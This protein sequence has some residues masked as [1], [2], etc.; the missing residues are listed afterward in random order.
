MPVLLHDLLV[1]ARLFMERL[2][3][4]KLRGGAGGGRAAPVRAGR[5]GE[6]RWG[7]Q[8]V[9][10]RPRAAVGRPQ[11]APL[12]SG[13]SRDPGPAAAVKILLSRGC[14]GLSASASH[15]VRCS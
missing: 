8:V 7:V 14:S 1:P 2:L 13:Q 4:A 3:Y 9:R 15:D 12:F 5:R 10:A 6:R 11:T